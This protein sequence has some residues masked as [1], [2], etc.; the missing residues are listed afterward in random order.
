MNAADT[1]EVGRRIG[2]RLLLAST[3]GL[4]LL[5][6]P[7]MLLGCGNSAVQSGNASE[8]AE[9]APGGELSGGRP[10]FGPPAGM[11]LFQENCAACHTEKGMEMGGRAV[12]NL[13]TLRSMSP[14]RIFDVM[15]NGK[16]KEQAAGLD[17]VQKK[18]VAE[19][20]GGRPMMD[21]AGTD[22]KA[23]SNLCKANPEF[24]LRAG[25]WN[26]WSPQGSNARFQ[27]AGGLAAGDVP[28]LKLKWAFGV[29]QAAS[30]F[31][32]PAAAG[33]RLFFGS[34]N[35]TVYGIDADS[36]CAYWSF[37]GDGGIRTAPVVQ[38]VTG[39]KE[40][41]A[42]I[43]ASQSG[44]VFAVGART[45]QLL[46]KMK[47]S[48]DPHG[49]TG[50]IGAWGGRVY[51]PFTGTETMAGA[52]P[53]YECCKSSGGVASIDASTGK[54]VWYASSIQEPIVSRG[55][56]E[57]GVPMWGPSGASVWNT[58]TID[59]KRKLIYFGTGNSYNEPA[60]ATSDSIVAIDM[61]TGK[62]RWH[63]QEIAGDAFAL[64]C[65]DTAPA[66]NHCPTKIGPDWD[67][68]GS[69]VILKTLP[70]GKDVVIGAG[71]AGVAVAVDPD[72]QGKVV[73]RTKLYADKPP[74]ADGLVIFG[75][76]AD[77]RYVYYP[78]QRPGGGLT[79]LDL[80]TGKMAWTTPMRADGRGQIGPASVMPGMIFTGGWDGT[81]RAVDPAGKV[82][83]TFDTKREFQT[84]NGIPGKG[85]SLGQSGA[86]VANGRLYVASGYVGM[87]NGSAGNVIL[88][89][90]PK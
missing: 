39:Q 33:G 83:W 25:D 43:F 82:V 3:T 20:L 34:D 37:H 44:T 16:M 63:H 70:N 54:L 67:F 52:N 50:S 79:A 8:A 84:V 10:K 59:P 56:N 31:S 73:W 7:L 19:F 87:Q 1:G 76:G 57:I 11:K 22:V 2:P 27:N 71:K 68:G 77:N 46:W 49:L 53:K 75:G 32:Q 12:P 45:G 23:M 28:K 62:I 13:A 30:L 78:L 61:E 26:G 85:G 60:A 4:V 14:E 40:K 29:P 80:A 35:G 64:G 89:F 74:T 69:S 48:N 72:Q 58:P 24:A 47:P 21:A 17:R 6:A 81:L 55:K 86:V 42:V 41:F 38:P 90:S 15:L 88:A 5:A 36:G 9:V 18:Q 66:G 51:V 65:P